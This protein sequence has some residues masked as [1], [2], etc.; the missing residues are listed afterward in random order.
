[1]LCVPSLECRPFQT[2]RCPRLPWTLFCRQSRQKQLQ[3]S[4]EDVSGG[5]KRYLSTWSEFKE[6]QRDIVAAVSTIPTTNLSAQAR[7]VMRRA[8]ESYMTHLVLLTASF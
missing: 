1:M 5:R 6:S 8:Y 2:L 3:F 4:P 7:Q